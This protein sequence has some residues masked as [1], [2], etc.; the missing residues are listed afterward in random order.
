MLK[1]DE[2]L[3]DGGKSAMMTMKLR[4][5]TDGHTDRQTFRYQMQAY[6][7]QYVKQNSS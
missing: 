2:F 6:L 1:K 7:Y 4:P 3:I 5:D